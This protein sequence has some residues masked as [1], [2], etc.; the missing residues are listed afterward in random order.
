M[1]A[2]FGILAIAI[3][4]ISVAAPAQQYTLVQLGTFGG[5]NS[6]A[7]SVNNSGQVAGEANLP[8]DLSAHAYVYENG[9]KTDL[10][11]LG[12]GASRA[13]SINDSG[14]LTGDAELPNLRFHAFLYS[15]GTM[16]DLDPAHP[17]HLSFGASINA[18]G[19]ILGYRN[20]APVVFSGGTVAS[21]P[22]G[23]FDAIDAV[24]INNAG[25]VAGTCV[26]G[27]TVVH[28][29]LVTG[30]VVTDLKPLPSFTIA[31]GNGINNLGDV[32][33]Q[34][35]KPNSET[36]LRPTL[37]S[38]GSRFNLG[39]PSGFTEGTC[40]ALNDYGQRVGNA[41]KNGSPFTSHAVLYNAL[42]GAKDLNQ[43]V[44]QNSGVVITDAV[45]ISNTG[46]IAASC[47]AATACLLEPN[48]IL[49]LK[50]YIFALEQGD[51]GCIQCGTV[52]IPEARSLPESLSDLTPTQQKRTIA[53]VDLIAIQLRQLER[54]RQITGPQTQLLLH[55]SQLVLNA[56]MSA[57]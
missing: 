52:L 28:A 4:T 23:S 12:G 55:Q 45:S 13:L 51:P 7:Y 43:L 53:T 19:A 26:K 21:V 44:S 11:T 36:S 16:Q 27:N 31:D 50:K 5:T 1:R 20:Y 49:I 34:S 38:G 41:T 25:Q 18:S 9:S 57:R 48:F 37:W 2:G 10:G 22:H 30:A 33:G 3:V 39:L 8:G 46:Y 47:N 14:Q 32:C 6:F 29:C 35:L 15:S 40:N 24:E 56:I 17:N 42:L 54:A